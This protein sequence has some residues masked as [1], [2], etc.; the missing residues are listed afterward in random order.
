MKRA[1]NPYAALLA[2]ATLMLISNG[3]SAEPPDPR[4]TGCR[5]GKGSHVIPQL[6]PQPLPPGSWRWW[7]RQWKDQPGWT[8]Q[9]SIQPLLERLPTTLPRYSGSS[10]GLT[11]RSILSRKGWTRW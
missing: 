2:C 10:P 7:R 6:N 8:D 11:R 1:S 3:A 4:K 5:T 9:S